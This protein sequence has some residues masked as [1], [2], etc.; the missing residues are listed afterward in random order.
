[1][2]LEKCCEKTRHFDGLTWI[3]NELLASEIFSGNRNF[4][5]IK[6]K[7]RFLAPPRFPL[8]VFELHSA[9]G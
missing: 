4:E 3:T 1:M 7:T 9:R 8:D 6:Y 5:L 2:R